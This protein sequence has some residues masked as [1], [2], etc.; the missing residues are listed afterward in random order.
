MSAKMDSTP[1]QPS[2]PLPSTSAAFNFFPRPTIRKRKSRT[3]SPSPSNVFASQT[4]HASL[5][6]TATNPPP[7][8]VKLHSHAF[9]ELRKS[10]AEGDESFVQ[11]MRAL[12][13]TRATSSAPHTKHRRGRVPGSRTQSHLRTQSFHDDEYDE[14]DEDD[15]L[16]VADG[17]S[18]PPSKK[19]R[20]G[21]HTTTSIPSDEVM[22][23]DMDISPRS[24]AF[25]S[26][27]S[28]YTT[29]PALST[30]SS[31]TSLSLPGP[32][33]ITSRTSDSQS[34]ADSPSTTGFAP[35]LPTSAAPPVP[36]TPPPVSREEKVVAALS[37]ALANGVGL[38]DY[39]EVR[40]AQEKLGG[41][42]EA[43]FHVGDLWH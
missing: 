7:S 26:S 20:S 37:L 17:P 43:D 27:S 39:R 31:L 32:A 8:A 41:K 42:A 10:L 4:S 29:T 21:V 14:S 23:V 13:S 28:I 40:E 1:T 35:W 5:S 30:D 2:R 25:P 34:L 19:A 22:D 38:N 3:V 33:N 11:R 6:S 12:E 9:G 15:I 16:I 18:S 24:G 36:G